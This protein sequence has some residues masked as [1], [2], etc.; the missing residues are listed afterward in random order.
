MVCTGTTL[1]PYFANAETFVRNSTFG[2]AFHRFGSDFSRSFVF[3]AETFK[4]HRYTAAVR[5][6]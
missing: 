5:V 2:L 4:G 3:A 1:Y 6:G